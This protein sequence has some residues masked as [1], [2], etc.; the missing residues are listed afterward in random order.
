MESKKARFDLLK[1]YLNHLLVI[2]VGVSGGS[3]GAVSKG[4]IG[5]LT[6]LGFAVVLLAIRFYAIIAKEANETLK[7]IK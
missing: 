3:F 5:V 6:W 1:T 7:D 4:K 2:I